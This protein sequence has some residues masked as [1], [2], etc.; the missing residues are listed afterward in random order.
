MWDNTAQ[1]CRL[2]LCQ[3][4]DFAGYLE[5]S[6]INVRR[7]FMYFWKSNICTDKLDGQETDLGLTQLNR[8]RAH[9]S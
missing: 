1:Q 2:G 5:D 6:N 4:F 7:T 8:S 3:D 9:L